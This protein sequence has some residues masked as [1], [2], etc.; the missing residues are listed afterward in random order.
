MV[1]SIDSKLKQNA[2]DANRGSFSVMPVLIETR[3][4]NS[5]LGTG[6][7]AIKTEQEAVSKQITSTP[8]IQ[9]NGLG[10]LS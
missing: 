3:V 2:C 9:E 5:M 1:H 6:C 8:Y 4:V 7:D 10:M